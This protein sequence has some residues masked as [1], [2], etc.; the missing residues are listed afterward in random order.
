MPFQFISPFLVNDHSNLFLDIDFMGYPTRLHFE[1]EHD[2][3]HIKY[4]YEPHVICDNE[5]SSIFLHLYFK[6][7]EGGSFIK[8]LAQKVNTK[9]VSYSYA[10]DPGIILYEEFTQ[11]SEKKSIIPPLPISPWK[12]DFFNLHASAVS[13]NNNRGYVFIGPSFSGKSIFSLSLSEQGYKF[14]TDDITIISKRTAEIYPLYRP[15][16]IRPDTIRLLPFLEGIPLENTV[17]IDRAFDKK[18]MINPKYLPI[19]LCKEAIKVCYVIFLNPSGQ[20]PT[21]ASIVK[22]EAYELLKSLVPVE[23][24]FNEAAGILLGGTANI[25]FYTLS[26]NYNDLHE[27]VSLIKEL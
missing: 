27:A 9:Q 17:I 3:N 24:E 8:S 25:S 21:C 16:G 1:S 20:E 5:P 13:D 4:Y 23:E 12:E 2:I 6:V 26:Y 22:S 19:E 18:V 15:V 11:A 7:K 10:S 14:L